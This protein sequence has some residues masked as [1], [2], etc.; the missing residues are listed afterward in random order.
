MRRTSNRGWYLGRWRK[1]HVSDE[2]SVGKI[3]KR[4]NLSQYLVLLT[5]FDFVKLMRIT[6][7]VLLFFVKAT[8][9]SRIQLLQEGKQ[10]FTVFHAEVIG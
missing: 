5:R 1:C 6:T 8:K 9:N 4:V 2:K 10:W 3:E 7:I